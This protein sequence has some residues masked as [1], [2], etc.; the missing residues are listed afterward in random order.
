[1]TSFYTVNITFII[2]SH[3]NNN[4]IR[5]CKGFI[6]QFTRT[7]QEE[8]PVYTSIISQLNY[9]P[10]KAVLSEYND[11]SHFNATFIDIICAPAAIQADGYICHFALH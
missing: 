7:P 10:T 6:I 8:K 3:F 11:I 9:L 1:M 4:V 5:K 2:N